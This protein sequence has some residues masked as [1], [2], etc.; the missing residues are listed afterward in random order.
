MPESQTVPVRRMVKRLSLRPSRLGNP[1]RKP[2]GLSSSS[3]KRAEPRRQARSLDSN[4]HL[5]TTVQEYFHLQETKADKYDLLNVQ[6][7]MLLKTY[8]RIID[9]LLLR[10]ERLESILQNPACEQ[11]LT[12]HP[13]SD[14]R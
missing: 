4:N 14:A 10:K 5:A 3:A 1:R 2:K 6:Q 12:R 8:G 13:K 11:W 9:I 7:A